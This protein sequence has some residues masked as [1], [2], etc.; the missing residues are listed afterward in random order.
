MRHKL[1]SLFLALQFSLT[2]SP[3]LRGNIDYVFLLGSNSYSDK[4]RLYEHFCSTFSSFKL[5]DNVFSSMTENHGCMVIDNTSLSNKLED[6]IFWYRAD[7]TPPFRIGNSRYWKY[8][9]RKY[10]KEHNKK[11]TSM[12][13]KNIKGNEDQIKINYKN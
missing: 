1:A 13:M 6:T 4:K 3:A 10:D 11:D 8:H 9:R 7:P 5:F 12:D 2:L